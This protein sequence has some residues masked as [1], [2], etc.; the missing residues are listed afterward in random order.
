MG[1]GWGIFRGRTG[2]PSPHS[3][4]AIQVVLS[5]KPV[6]VWTELLG[7]SLEAGLVL[8]PGVRHALG[9]SDDA[10]T[11]VYLEPDAIPG[12]RVRGALR[13]GYLQ[14]TGTQRREYERA[15]EAQVS[16][17]DFALAELL[18]SQAEATPAATS[19]DSRIDALLARLDS[20]LDTPCSVAKLA[21]MCGMSPSHFQ[22]RFRAQTGMAVRP[23]IRWRRLLKALQGVASGSSLTVAAYAAGFSDAAHLSR[24]MRRHFGITP[25]TLADMVR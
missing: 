23:Y 1:L 17:P 7:S 5:Q 11:L 21:T 6:H 2:D 25:G 8:G 15:I 10:I 18:G 16:A 20:L 19:S 4:Y 22:H 12:R 24:T 14:L 3:H 13:N 9:S